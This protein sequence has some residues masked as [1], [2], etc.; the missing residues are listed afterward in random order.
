[1]SGSDSYTCPGQTDWC[2]FG[3]L[4]RYSAAYVGPTSA[5]RPSISTNWFE[6][7]SECC[8]SLLAHEAK[9][10]QGKVGIG[11]PSFKQSH[12]NCCLRGRMSMQGRCKTAWDIYFFPVWRAKST[13]CSRWLIC[14]IEEGKLWGTQTL[15]AIMKRVAFSLNLLFDGWDSERGV[16]L[17]GGRLF[18]LTELRGDWLWHKQL[19]NFTSSWKSLK[20]ICYRCDCVGRSNDPKDLYWEIDKGAWHEYSRGEFIAC[21]LRD[22]HHPSNRAWNYYILYYLQLFPL[23]PYFWKNFFSS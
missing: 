23:K 1:M 15:N 21:Q 12:S 3:Y 4:W 5:C 2:S 17:A 14:G 20:N 19:W 8:E 16:P 6:H 7:P 11:F 18:T 22:N 10:G 9:C 13:R